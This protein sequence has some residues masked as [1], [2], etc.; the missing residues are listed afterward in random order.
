VEASD[1]SQEKR[2]LLTAV[3]V[4]ESHGLRLGRKDFL[5]GKLRC[6]YQNGWEGIWKAKSED[7]NTIGKLSM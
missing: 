5:K 2:E 4:P 6:G 1:S 7:V 3:H